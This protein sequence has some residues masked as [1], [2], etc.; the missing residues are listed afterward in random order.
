MS[1][2]AEY[3]VVNTE[4]NDVPAALESDFDQVGYYVQGSYILTGE[5][6]PLENRIK[7][8]NNL[9]LSEGNLGAFELAARFSVLDT[10]DGE[11]AGVVAI[12]ANQKTQEI[13]IGLN[14]WWT[15]N[16]A[17]RLNWVHLGYDEDRIGIKT[18]NED[19]DS[20]DIF[21]VRWQID[22]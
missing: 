4:L 8:R 2:R 22:F 7:P 6:K 14:W 21:Y 17:L 16:I 19:D 13:V 15:H 1:V 3:G 10:S 18:G 5:D 12:T 11:D 20:Q 9:N